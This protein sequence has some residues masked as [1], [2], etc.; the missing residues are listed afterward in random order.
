MIRPVFPLTLRGAKV[1]ALASR[2]AL[3]FLFVGTDETLHATALMVRGR[4]WVFA[5]IG[6]LAREKCS[7]RFL[8]NAHLFRHDH[9]VR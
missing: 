7:Q 3:K 9:A 4:V 6:R 5:V 8:I 1:Q 2:A